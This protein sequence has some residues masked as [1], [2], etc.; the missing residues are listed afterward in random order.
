MLVAGRVTY[1]DGFPDDGQ[2]EW[3]FCY[4]TNYHV[5]LKQIVLVPC[6]AARWIPVLEKRDGYPRNEQND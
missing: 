3:P 5:L 6:D 1:D 2:Q 4:Q